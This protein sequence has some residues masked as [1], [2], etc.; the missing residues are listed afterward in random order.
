MHY[1]YQEKRFKREK[2]IISAKI[3]SRNLEYIRETVLCLSVTKKSYLET[4]P[5]ELTAEM[6][7]ENDYCKREQKKTKDYLFSL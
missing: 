3:Y 6:C 4:K 1:F 7:R 2:M 5:A